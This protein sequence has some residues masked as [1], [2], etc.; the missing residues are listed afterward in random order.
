MKES[1]LHIRN[2]SRKELDR[3]IDWAAAEGWNPGRK[4]P[5]CFFTA[6]PEGFLIGELNGEPV[7]SISVVRYG[8][9]FAFLGLYI[10]RPE[11][12]GQG[13]GLRIWQEG[14]KRLAGFNIGLDG[15]VAQQPNYRK[16]GFSPTYRNIR[17]EGVTD[18][19]RVED[20][21]LVDLTDLPFA[22]V[23]AYDR[24][25]VPAPR[26]GFL[27]HWLH[28]SGHQALGLMEEGNLQG[29]GVIRPCRS[30]YKI[31][32]L[33]AESPDRAETLL[34]AL[35]SRVTPGQPF[36]LD[37]PEPNA[38]ALALANRHNMSPVFETTRMYTGSFPDIPLEGLYGVTSFELG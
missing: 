24:R 37:T 7:A 25:Y 16:S 9:D 36:Y 28:A 27:K 6:D 15:V 23:E 19:A 12:R 1:D 4:D 26:S 38:D 14:M 8:E 10:V 17:Q 29:I 11:F 31:G 13:F 21:R 30:G 34:T 20:P 3:V 2:M 5:E 18:G 22:E 33:F 35:L 32:P